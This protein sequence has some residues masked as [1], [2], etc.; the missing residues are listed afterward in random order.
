MRKEIQKGGS[1][2][3]ELMSSSAE[4]N[5]TGSSTEWGL[6]SR[7]SSLGVLHGGH[8]R[9]GEW[10]SRVSGGPPWGSSLEVLHRL[11]F[12]W[13]SAMGSS[14]WGFSTGFFLGVLHGSLHGFS[15]RLCR[16]CFRAVLQR[17]KETSGIYKP[18][19]FSYSKLKLQLLK[20]E[21]INTLTIAVCPKCGLICTYVQ[22][23][24]VGR[25]RVAGTSRKK[26]SEWR[27]SRSRQWVY[28]NC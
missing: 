12:S 10:F 27:R 5:L 22:R 1:Q 11:V 17:S 19:P 4:L 21:Y 25:L 18:I 13:G 7:G 3:E 20:V 16:T 15:R 6:F 8:P 9:G 26:P 28:H 2:A 14:M 23:K 24:L